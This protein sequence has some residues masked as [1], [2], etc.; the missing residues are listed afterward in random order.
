MKNCKNCHFLAKESRRDDGH[1]HSS[2]LSS[3]ERENLNNIS[4]FYSLKCA[5][6]VWD[7]GVTPSL[8]NERE[9]IIKNENR[10]DFC[11]HLEVHEGMLFDAASELQKRKAEYNQYNRSNLY[12][13]IGLGIA[14]T[15]L[16]VDV[17]VSIIK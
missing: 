9:H 10:A 2:S 16:V 4:N 14:I 13:Q 1:V 17:I 15:A 7:E 5:K 12:T 6:G 8:V 11:F 3:S